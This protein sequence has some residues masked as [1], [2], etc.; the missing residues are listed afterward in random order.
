[1]RC[2]RLLAG[3]LAAASLALV[4]TGAAAQPVR[5][6]PRI[7]LTSGELARLT[8]IAQQGPDALRR[9]LWRTRMI[10]AWTWSDLVHEE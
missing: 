1:M 6:A 4:V 8:A 9:F 7:Q 3:A 5:L 2:T 10:Y